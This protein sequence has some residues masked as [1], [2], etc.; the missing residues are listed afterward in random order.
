MYN[1]IDL[2]N[3]DFKIAIQLFKRKY[4]EALRKKDRREILIIHGYGAYK[5][6]HRPVLAIKLREYLSKNRDKLDYR[7]DINPGV[8]YVNPR[9]KLE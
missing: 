2:H 8:T 3:L 9:F 4:N 5:F 6:D 1:E 7:L